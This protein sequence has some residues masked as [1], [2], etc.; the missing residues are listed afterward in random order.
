M[1]ELLHDYASAIV[2]VP[3]AMPDVFNAG[4]VLVLPALK[5]VLVEGAELGGRAGLSQRKGNFLVTL[6][7]PKENADMQTAAWNMADALAAGFRMLSL[8]CTGGGIVY[9]ADP[10][11]THAGATPDYRLSLMVTVPWVSWT[12]GEGV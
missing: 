4:K 8:P 3:E 11:I 2:I 6:S 9:M 10:Y 7:V 1:V 5:P 12:G